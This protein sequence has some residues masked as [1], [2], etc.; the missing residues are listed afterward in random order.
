MVKLVK[1]KYANSV[2]QYTF[3]SNGDFKTGDVLLV[4][5]RLGYQMAQAVCDTY[6]E[7]DAGI[8]CAWAL[9]KVDFEKWDAFIAE[10][11]QKKQKVKEILSTLAEKRKR[12]EDLVA[13]RIMAQEDSEV[14]D[15]LKEL[16]GLK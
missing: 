11:E 8:A 7:E 12:F 4:K 16:E 2:T 6:L 3:L 10:Q 15:L 5:S 13:Y 1:V 9:D 14:A